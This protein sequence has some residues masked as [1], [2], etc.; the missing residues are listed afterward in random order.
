MK[1]LVSC[2]FLAEF[3]FTGTAVLCVLLIYL[4]LTPAISLPLPATEP[5]AKEKRERQ[6]LLLGILVCVMEVERLGECG[7]TY[8]D[9]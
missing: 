7:P 3:F 5:F 4:Y 8:S 1:D 2:Q 9:V 6:L